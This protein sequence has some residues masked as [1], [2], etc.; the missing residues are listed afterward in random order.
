VPD[1]DG[2]APVTGRNLYDLLTVVAA[3]AFLLAVTMFLV[4]HYGA[5]ASKAGTI[6]GILIPAIGAIF[7][8][9]IAY[10]TGTSNGRAAGKEQGRSEAKQLLAP[11]LVEIDQQVTAMVSTIRREGES[12]RGVDGLRVD[13]WDVRDSDLADVQATVKEA[14]SYL[15]AM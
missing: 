9:T 11:K 2:G 12:T 14:R 6:L 15:D 4:D 8:V 7:G 5:D 10:R 13:G 1:E 3:L